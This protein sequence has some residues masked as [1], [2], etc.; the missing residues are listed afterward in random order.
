MQNQTTHW[1]LS[2]CSYPTKLN[3]VCQGEKFVCQPLVW[4]IHTKSRTRST[5][6]ILVRWTFS[7]IHVQ[8]PWYIINCE[9]R[10]GRISWWYSFQFLN[11]NIRDKY[12]GVPMYVYSVP[13]WVYCDLGEEIR[14]GI[15]QHTLKLFMK[16]PFTT[17][18]SCTTKLLFFPIIL[19]IFILFPFLYVSK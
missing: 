14:P 8:L 1:G 17:V 15:Q 12:V 7:H 9:K 6:K 5:G 18:V 13:L 4:R 3:K 16:L 11:I 19:F 10:S 2:K